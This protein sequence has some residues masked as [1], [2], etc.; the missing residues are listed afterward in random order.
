[1]KRVA[2]RDQAGNAALY[3][4]MVLAVVTVLGLGVWRILASRTPK[5][6]TPSASTPQASGSGS[7]TS[8]PL[9]N[10]TDNASLSK[11]ITNIGSSLNEGTQNLQAATTA[12]NDE[13]QVVDVPTN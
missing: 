4:V 5:T 8:K 7:Q 3:M 9:T 12:T 2:L 1:M 6:N 13:S 11:D 10:S